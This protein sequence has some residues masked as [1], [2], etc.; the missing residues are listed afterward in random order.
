MNTTHIFS[1][2][3]VY[4]ICKYLKLTHAIAKWLTIA[5]LDL[6]KF[7][8]KKSLIPYFSPCVHVTK[9]MLDSRSHEHETLGL[10]LQTRYHK[11]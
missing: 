5:H 6:S 11:H 8:F 7:G 1:I 4:E 3:L 9:R 2:N 10:T